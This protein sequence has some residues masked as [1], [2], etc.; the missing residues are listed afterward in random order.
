MI[1]Y[2]IETN[3]HNIKKDEFN[4]SLGLVLAFIGMQL[5]SALKNVFPFDIVEILMLLSFFLLFDINGVKK[6]KV[7]KGVL[8]LF[9]FQL[10]LTIISLISS[11]STVQLISFHFYLLSL[12]IAFISHTHQYRYIYFSKILFYL[13]GFISII[14]CFYATNG[15][16]QLNLT[17]EGTGKLWLSRGG[18]PITMPRALVIN[19]ISI[20]IYRSKN[21]IEKFLAYI[22]SFSDVIGL[23]AFS[24]RSS[25]LCAIII[26][27][28]W[29]YLN[30]SGHITLR[31]FCIAFVCIIVCAILYINSNYIQQS[32]SRVYTAIINGI[33]AYLGFS[34]AYDAS[35]FHRITVLEELMNIY[36]HRPVYYFFFG[37]GYNY[38]YVDRPIIQIFLDL[39]IIITIFY[40]YYLIFK[41][42]SNLLALKF[43]KYSHIWLSITLLSIQPLFDQFYCGLPYYYYL[44]L[45][46]IFFTCEKN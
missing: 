15:F 43:Q 17:F 32:I 37:M 41:P 18:D 2:K 14:I 3:P 23:F 6:V 5:N 7:S 44:W 4:K 33:A 45:P 29:V 9:V 30:Y 1:N 35:A 27:L 8:I 16:R 25:I 22:F 46:C 34:D 39:G 12:I 11:N 38:I 19:I 40:I 26:L 28:Y 31:K 20:I 21:N 13:S 24:N 10:T 36:N 42:I